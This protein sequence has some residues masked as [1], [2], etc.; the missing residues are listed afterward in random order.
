M[1]KYH[2]WSIGCQMNKADSRRLADRLEEA[3][4]S[5]S[6]LV[7]EADVVVLNSCVVRESAERRVINKL[8]SLR[9]VKKRCPRMVVILTGCM[10]GSDERDLKKRFP[11]VDLFLPPQGWETFAEWLDGRAA[12]Q[13]SAKPVAVRSQPVSAFVPVVHGC[14]SFC[15][16]CIVPYRRGRVKSRPVDEIVSEVTELVR[17][18]TKEVCLLGQIV[19]QYG[20]DLAAK[21]DLADLLEE[22]NVIEGLAR[23][24]FLTSHPAYMNARLVEAV[25][26]LEK[27][28][29]HI[30]LPVQSGDDQ[31]LAAMNRGYTVRQYLDLVRTIRLQVA[32]PSISTDVVVG[33]PGETREQFERTVELLRQV[34]FDKVHVAAYSPRPETYSAR[35]L[36]DDV[37][38]A[39]KELRRT[40]VESLQQRIAGEINGSLTGKTVEVL[41]DGWKKG[42]WQGRTRGDKLVFFP[43]QGDFL[44]QLVTVRIERASPFALQGRWCRPEAE[45]LRL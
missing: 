35:A 3:G 4:Y 5:D 2:I 43:G 14:N 38:P 28:C 13:G 32:G 10:V 27:V 44:G 25:A 23:I 45:S 21:R 19:D 8:E 34:R 6:D 36:T 18:G 42:K 39:D 29:E 40:L 16:Y 37:P 24:R 15:S 33:F 30:S 41:V 17:E 7:G 26:R 20:F 12:S 31:V 22:L 11:W 9:G 1:P